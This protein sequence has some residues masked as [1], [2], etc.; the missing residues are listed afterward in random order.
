M[1]KLILLLFI[2][3][4]FACSK[5]EKFAIQPSSGVWET[6]TV[7]VVYPD[8]IETLFFT[9]ISLAEYYTSSEIKYRKRIKLDST[10]LLILD[11]VLS[12]ADFNKTENSIGIIKNSY[13]S[14]SYS[15][16]KEWS[17]NYSSNVEVM[18]N[19]KAPQETQKPIDSLYATDNVRE[20][21][22]YMLKKAKQDDNSYSLIEFNNDEFDLYS[23]WDFNNMWQNFI[24]NKT[25]KD[26]FLQTVIYGE[27]LVNMRNPQIKKAFEQAK[28]RS[29]TIR[30]MPNKVVESNLPDI[31]FGE[32]KFKWRRVYNKKYY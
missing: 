17:S 13:E 30:I 4:V 10:N 9:D 12:S 14:I 28:E 18:K 32:N 19:L 29:V 1:K 22:I 7:L 27:E 6:K 20:N 5:D 8:K 21:L 16:K 2:P 31:L 15:N 26:L 23:V 11:K 3:L 24:V 25:G